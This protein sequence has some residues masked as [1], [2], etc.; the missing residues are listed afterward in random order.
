MVSRRNLAVRFLLLLF[1]GCF[2]C[3]ASDPAAIKYFHAS[4]VRFGF[5][6]VR[7]QY[8][9]SLQTGYVKTRHLWV[10]LSSFPCSH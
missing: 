5:T 6:F 1:L 7:V 10:P 3:L 9:D 4:P 8:R 2:F